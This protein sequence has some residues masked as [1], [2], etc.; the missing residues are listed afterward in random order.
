MKRSHCQKGEWFGSRRCYL[1]R[2]DTGTGRSW[3]STGDRA[4][5]GESAPGLSKRKCDFMGKNTR[6]PRLVTSQ[7]R[8]LSL[9]ALVIEHGCRLYRYTMLC[10]M[11]R[12]IPMLI[13]EKL[14]VPTS[15][16]VKGISGAV[17]GTSPRKGESGET[18]R[19]GP[20]SC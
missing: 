5:I 9:V 15:L 4:D 3:R 1:S 11:F 17:E 13:F 14:V 12:H 8:A 20:S 19:I 6:V 16:L 2:G 18:K 10:L 7:R